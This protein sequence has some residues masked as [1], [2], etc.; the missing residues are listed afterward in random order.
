MTD[1]NATPQPSEV[2]PT[3]TA[4]P[5][6]T[7]V[8]S[9]PVEQVSSA[10]VAESTLVGESTASAPPQEPSSPSTETT[11]I[12]SSP[13]TQDSA[14]G[15]TTETVSSPTPSVPEPQP[16]DSAGNLIPTPT[17]SPEVVVAPVDEDEAARQ[18]KYEEDWSRHTAGPTVLTESDGTPIKPWSVSTSV[19]NPVDNPT[20]P[21]PA[22]TELQKLEDF[23]SEE[24]SHLVAEGE[25]VVETI[26]RLI[27]NTHGA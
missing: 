27:S 15:T 3:E 14:T 9:V 7:S 16:V 2:P 23:L 5:V 1:V 8:G 26:K 19:D 22:E 6:D 21:H 25:T 20:E 13:A 11:L 10:P 4:A 12:G 17:T 18:A 24:F